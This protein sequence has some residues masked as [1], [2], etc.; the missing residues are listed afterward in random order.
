[1]IFDKFWNDALFFIKQIKN[2]NHLLIS[3]PEFFKEFRDAVPYAY[4]FY[5]KSSNFDIVCIHKGQIDN[6]CAKF[7]F[8]ILQSHKYVFGNEVFNIFSN[9]KKI[10][11]CEY[12]N[13]FYNYKNWLDERYKSTL[14]NKEKKTKNNFE[15]III[16]N[17]NRMGNVGDDALA[18]ATRDILLNSFVNSK[19]EILKQPIP[20][21]FIEKADLVVFGGG[22]IY[23][24]R[25]LNNAINYTNYMNMAYD[26]GVPHFGIGIGTQ[27]IYSKIGSYIL[28][29]ALNTSEFTIVRDPLDKIEL[30]RIGVNKKI[31]ITNDLVFSLPNVTKDKVLLKEKKLQN[32]G[33]VLIDSLKLKSS[34]Y[35][36]NYRKVNNKLI[37]FLIKN[38]KKIIYICQSKDD[39]DYYRLL[40]IK[41]GGEIREISFD[42]ANRGFDYYSDLDLVI[43]SRLHGLIFSILAKVP[44]ISVS[45]SSSKISRLIKYQFPRLLPNLITI[46]GYSLK[47]VKILIKKIK[48]KNK[49]IPNNGE[50]KKS[51][52]LAN[53]TAPLISKLFK[54]GR[55]FSSPLY[56]QESWK[57]RNSILFTMLMEKFKFEKNKNLK[58]AEFGCGPIGPFTKICLEKKFKFFSIKIDKY[59]WDN[60][61]I[62]IDLNSKFI[63]LPRVD[64]SVLSGVLEYL[65]NPLVILKKILDNTDLLL[66]SYTPISKTNFENDEKYLLKIERRKDLGMK[67]HYTNLDITNYVCKYGQIINS[68]LYHNQSLFLIKKF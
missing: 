48:N 12:N 35:L 56:Y 52:A 65:N 39:L 24:D 50:I 41:F 47:K 20:R 43:T 60:K 37:R 57:E 61:T 53:F 68:R 34:N 7:I 10:S 6:F 23:Y 63:K 11:I 2:K 59:K 5:N 66:F 29:N 3:P 67:N 55:P 40:K 4:S 46:K 19:V 25:D 22:G 54:L 32:I 30:E 31:M 42:Q 13:H 36:I 9:I 21:K 28:R 8:E 26:A 64:I 51:I 14:I 44:V 15:N 49:F 33:I 27:G 58:I 17:A 16:I 18:H 45:A 62:V 1:M 38:K